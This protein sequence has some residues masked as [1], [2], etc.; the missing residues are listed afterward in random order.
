MKT[1]A[2]RSDFDFKFSGFRVLIFNLGFRVLGFRV[3]GF[4]VLGFVVSESKRNLNATHGFEDVKG[5]AGFAAIRISHVL[6]PGCINHV[7]S[8]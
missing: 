5:Y 6:V 2:I 8:P 4:R 1:L 7:K 3:L